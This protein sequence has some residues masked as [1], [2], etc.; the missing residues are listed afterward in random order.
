MRGVAHPPWNPGTGEALG[1]ANYGGRSADVVRRL[2][3]VVNPI[4]GMGGRVGLKGTDGVVDEARA[5]GA[6]PVAP[7]RARTFA[8]TLLALSHADPSLSIRW[9]TAA[10]PMGT[11]PLRAAG[12]GEDFGEIVYH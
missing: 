10:G 1:R 3:F 4:A 7:L 2:G 12:I 5:A 9:L 8:E 6:E 11:E